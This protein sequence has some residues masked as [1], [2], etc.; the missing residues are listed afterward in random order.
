MLLPKLRFLHSMR[1]RNFLESALTEGLMLRDH[2]VQFAP[3]NTHAHWRSL[4]GDAWNLLMGK[5]NSLG[6]PWEELSEDQKNLIMGGIGSISGAIPMLCFTEVPEGRDVA[7]HLLSFGGYG[8]VVNRDWLESSGGDRVIYAGNNSPVSRNLFRVVASLQITNL[9]LDP[10][11]A[12]VFNITPFRPVLDLLAHV[13]IRDNLEEYEWRITGQHGFMGGKR[14]S[15][16]RLPLPIE[17]VE[18]VLVQNNDDVPL[19]EELVLSIAT[20]QSASQV[21]SVI[22]QPAVLGVAKLI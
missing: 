16:K 20:I 8:L 11:G 5:L 3:A 7:F 14:E 19:L 1:E 4:L 10:G 2:M 6:A 12:V 17:Q 22:C 21:P 9:G 15:G 13:E 18:T